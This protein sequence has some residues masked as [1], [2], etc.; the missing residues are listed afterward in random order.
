[1][2]EKAESVK[3]V[4]CIVVICDDDNVIGHSCYGTDTGGRCSLYRGGRGNR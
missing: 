2:Y 4:V 3:D 1:M